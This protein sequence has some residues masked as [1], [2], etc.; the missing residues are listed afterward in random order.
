MR[1]TQNSLWTMVQANL[2]SINTRTRELEEQAVTGLAI[3]RPSDAPELTAQLDQ[4]SA[5]V[6]DQAVYA[7]NAGQATGILDTMDSALARGHDALTR[8]R[9]IAIEMSNGTMTADER[10]A[11]ADEITSLRATILDVAN[12]TYAGRYI[13][14]GTAYDEAPFADDGS[15]SGSTDEPSTRVGD[16]TWVSTGRDGSAIF[17]DG[18]DILAAL[19]DFATALSSDDDAGITAAIDNIDLG[20]DA[21]SSARTEVGNDTNVALDATE[22]S[23]SLGTELQTRV[24]DLAAADPTETYMKLAEMRNAYTTALQVAASSKSNSLFDLL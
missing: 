16:N 1:V 22:L 10:A 21:M 7:K 11:A 15:Y 12:S 2:G 14:A 24:D 4:L 8:C 19:D 5:G 23:E 18:V 9:E 13:F 6:A 3:S 20:L 17:S